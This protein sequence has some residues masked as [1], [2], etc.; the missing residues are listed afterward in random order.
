MARQR[1]PDPLRRRQVR[2]VL[3][4]VAVVAASLVAVQAT[5]R[6]VAAPPAFT[7]GGIVVYR[8]GDGAAALSNTGSAVFLDEYGTSGALVQSLAMPTAPS[9]ANHALIAS[10]PATSEGLLTRSA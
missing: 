9:G 5:P 3:A 4:L 6:A 8:V 7:P 1:Q 2:A 10:G